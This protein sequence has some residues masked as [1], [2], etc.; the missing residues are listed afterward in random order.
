MT[1]LNFVDI[2]EN[3]LL[4]LTMPVPLPHLNFLRLST[5]KLTSLVLPPG[6]TNLEVI[7][8]DGNQLTNLTLA[9]GLTNLAQIDLRGNRLASL[10][11]PPDATRLNTLVLDGN[12]LT[13]LVVSESMAAGTLAG[14]VTSLKNQGVSV[15]T[16]PLTVQLNSPRRSAAGAFV[17]TLTGPPGRY[18]IQTSTDLLNWSALGIVT[19]V[20]GSA[21]FTDSGVAPQKFFRAITAP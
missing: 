5:N 17:F 13:T 9:S 19:N 14:L 1:N 8:L 3:Q 20:L 4:A 21:D 7:F 6:M 12:P 15:F 18:G 16:Y 11:L 2:G 10:T